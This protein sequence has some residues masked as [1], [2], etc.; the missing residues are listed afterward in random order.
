MRVASY[1]GH[2]E[3]HPLRIGVFDDW[4]GAAG[5]SPTLQRLRAH[6]EI[7]IYSDRPS[8][9]QRM[10]RLADLDVLI[11]WRER[12]VLG[13][14]DI[15]AATHLR[16][17]A[18]TGYGWEHIDTEAMVEAG[19]AFAATKLA[20]KLDTAEF[21]LAMLFS[22]AYQ[23]P[24][25]DRRLRDEGW[26]ALTWKGLSNRRVS[27]LGYG[28]VAQPLASMTRA[29]GADV[30]VWSRSLT[31]GQKLA[32]GVRAVT[33][34]EALTT[35]DY[36]VTLLRLNDAT[37][38]FLSRERLGKLSSGA[39][40]VNTGRAGLVDQDA[41][42][43]ALREGRLGGAA[44]DVFEEEPLPMSHPLRQ[45]GNVVLTPHV[46]WTSTTLLESLFTA[47]AE[48][49]ID[50]AGGKPSGLITFPVEP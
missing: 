24:V 47:A 23:I 35:A 5:R 50:F 49:V 32:P 31:P 21:T 12:T 33:L 4:E 30:V 8:R 17:I 13:R 15:A 2:G 40:L 16:L 3:R 7:V 34:D 19:I 38:G 28:A 29:V 26:P 18:Q 20:A 10:E 9:R 27:I 43:D 11:L 48:Q 46:A 42:M 45:L 37:R 25:A 36:L 6:G 44:L 1:T 39:M 22:L 41:L 14:E